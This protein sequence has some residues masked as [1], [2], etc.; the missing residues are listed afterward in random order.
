MPVNIN[1]SPAAAPVAAA[2]FQ[3]G[4]GDYNRWASGM[5]L[6]Q[7]QLS[8]QKLL[9]QQQ[10][11]VQEWQTQYGAASD[12]YMQAQGINSQQTM[13]LRDL[14]NNDYLQQNSLANQRLMQL[15]DIAAQQFNNQQQMAFHA[16]QAAYG[17]QANLQSQILAGNIH[18]ALQ[19]Q[20]YQESL[21]LGQQNFDRQAALEDLQV[22]GRMKINRANIQDQLDFLPQ[23]SEA[24]YTAA[25]QNMARRFSALEEAGPNGNQTLT[26]EEYQQARQDLMQQQLGLRTKMPSRSDIANEFARNVFT[27]TTASIPDGNGGSIPMRYIKNPRTGEISLDPAMAQIINNTRYASANQAKLRQTM[28]AASV[29]MASGIMATVQKLIQADATGE[30]VKNPQIALQMAQQLARASLQ[31]SSQQFAGVAMDD[32]NNTLGE[33]GPWPGAE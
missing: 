13:Q 7:Q 19:A 30:L 14:Y 28:S 6:Q 32:P 3:G 31:F 10:M 12:Q 21:G 2:A 8:Q 15:N 9:A 29:N 17:Q 16:S 22:Q 5:A 18:S 23:M 1:Y 4:L 20:G 24:E 33:P 25:Q 26:P 27:D 11:Q